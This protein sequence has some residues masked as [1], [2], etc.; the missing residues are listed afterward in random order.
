ML[1]MSHSVSRGE[2]SESSSDEDERMIVEPLDN[3]LSMISSPI[4][5]PVSPTGGIEDDGKNFVDGE[6]NMEIMYWNECKKTNAAIYIGTSSMTRMNYRV[7]S[8]PSDF[9]HK[10]TMKHYAQMNQQL[11]EVR[12]QMKES[13]EV[14]TRINATMTRFHTILGTL[15]QISENMK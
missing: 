6:K 2:G 1:E 13:M 11:S 15:V 10:F 9:F 4:M 14:A 5:S 3:R 12:E 7:H 8:S